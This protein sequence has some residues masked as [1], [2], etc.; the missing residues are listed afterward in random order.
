MM[1]RILIFLLIAIS[2][3][4]TSCENMQVE[5][6]AMPVTLEIFVKDAEGNNL[7]DYAW[8]YGKNYVYLNNLIRIKG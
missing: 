1:K 7:L 4:I 3:V 8:L 5:A 2:S 6:D